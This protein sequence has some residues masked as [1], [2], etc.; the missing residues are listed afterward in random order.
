MEAAREL[1]Y[2][3]EIKRAL[4]E[5]MRDPSD[6]F[7]RF[8][9]TRIE[10]PGS[11]T[12]TRVQQFTSLVQQA[13]TQFVKD[14]IDARLKSAL[15]RGNEPKDESAHQ[16]TTAEPPANVK[17]PLDLLLDSNGVLAKARYEGGSTFIVLTGA[18]AAK[19]DNPS[20]PERYVQ[21]RTT[22]LQDGILVDQG[23][24]YRLTQ[25]QVF[26]SSSA[27][28]SILLASNRNGYTAWKDAQG[29]ILRD[30]LEP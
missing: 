10:Y 25:D 5:E 6:D 20:L 17:Y 11:K 26:N 27:A 19:G 22:L 8:I 14:L 7:V 23:N 15:E 12:K 1:K 9:L 24:T 13:F 16:E 21:M 30:I 2:T 4:S 29:R 18:L 3:N 28:A